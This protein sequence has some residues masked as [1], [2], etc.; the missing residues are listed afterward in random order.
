MEFI[1]IICF[2]ASNENVLLEIQAMTFSLISILVVLAFLVRNKGL[3]RFHKSASFEN[4]HFIYRDV[5]MQEK[6]IPS[7]GHIPFTNFKFPIS[8]KYLF[9]LSLLVL[10]M[11]T[12]LILLE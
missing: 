12:S 5:L 1:E 3:S 11:I 8:L 6:P 10:L 7:D 9:W 4:S 2:P